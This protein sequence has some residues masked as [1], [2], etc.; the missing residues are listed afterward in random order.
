MCTHNHTHTT[1]TH[2]HTCIHITNLYRHTH[3]HTHTRTG[4]ATELMACSMKADSLVQGSY[5]SSPTALAFPTP[6]PA[7]T[8][9]KIKFSKVI[10][11]TMFAVLSH[12]IRHAQISF[13]PF[14]VRL[15]GGLWV[16]L[17]ALQRQ[18]RGPPGQVPA[19]THTH[20]HTHTHL[21]DVGTCVCICVHT[22]THARTHTH[23]CVQYIFIC[24]YVYMYMY[25][26]I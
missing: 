23:T 1:H 5:I 3:T 25:V 10:A 17:Q 14:F 20:T 2:T 4:G 22:H 21:A 18:L 11:L 9:K 6:D 24:I 7:G 13:F 8:G 12:C 16:S 19:H 15:R 26:C